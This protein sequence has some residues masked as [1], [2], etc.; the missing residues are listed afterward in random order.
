[1]AKSKK[2]LNPDEAVLE[3]TTSDPQDVAHR[4]LAIEIP[5]QTIGRIGNLEREFGQIR[6]D[7]DK[8]ENHRRRE[9]D[10]QF[11]DLQR[12]LAE[13][14]KNQQ[15][16]MDEVC[17]MFRVL[18]SNQQQ[19]VERATQGSNTRQDKGKGLLVAP[20]YQ[21]DT[22]VDPNNI[23]HIGTSTEVGRRNT[24]A[25]PQDR[26]QQDAYGERT[27]CAPRFAHCNQNRAE[28]TSEGEQD[29]SPARQRRGSRFHTR[30][31]ERRTPSVRYEFPKFNREHLREWL[32]MA[33]RYFLCHHVPEEE[34]I[35]IATANMTG[36]ATTHF[37]WFN[38]NTDNQTW[39]KYKAS[40][41][42]QFGDST[43]IDYDEDLKNI[44]QTTTVPA[45]KRQ[46]ERL[47]SMVR[48]PEK[49]LIGALKGALRNDIKREMKI[50]R[51][52]KLEECIAM[53][54]LYEERIEER[55]AEKKAHKFDKQRKKNSYPSGSRNNRR[56]LVPYKKE[57]DPRPY[58][59]SYQGQGKKPPLR[60][61]TPQQ[62][63]EYRR[64]GLCYRCE[65]KWD[66]YHKCPAYFWVQVI[67]DVDTSSCTDSDSSSSASYESSSSSSEEEV[68][69]TRRHRHTEKKKEVT[70]E[71]A[72]TKEE[73]PTEAESL[74]SMQNPNK[75][76]SFRV[77]GRINGKKILTLLDNGATRNFLTEEAARKC[78]VLLES[79]QPQTIVV[80]GGL[81]LKC[82][83]EGKNMEIVI[84]KKSFRIDFLVIPLDGVDLILGMP[85]FFTLGIISWD[86][87]NF[88]MTFTPDGE[89]ESMTLQ[90]ITSTTRPKAALRAIEAAQPACWV[91][92]L[93]T[94]VPAKEEQEEIVPERIQKVFDQ[95]GDI[96]E[97]PKGRPPPR[98]YDHK[99]IMTQG[100]EPVNV[101]PYRYGYNQKA[102]IER[103]VK[104]NLES[105]IVQP[106]SSPFSSPVLLVKKKDNTWRFCVDYHA[107]NEATVKDRHPI[108]VIDELLDE[109]A[110]ATI[111]SKI[112]LRVGY[113]QIRMDKDDVPKTAFRTH[114][115]HYEFLVMPFGLT[116]TPA[117]F[118]RCMNDIFRQYLRNFILVFFDDILIYS[119]SEELH[120]QHLNVALQVLRDNQLYA[121]RSKCSFGQPSIGYLGHIVCQQGVR[122]DPE[123]LDAMQRW[124]LPKDMKG[125]RGFLGLT[126]YYR[127]FIQ[128]Y[129]LIAQPLTQM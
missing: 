89:T 94:D 19:G 21:T 110:G 45:Y 103:L 53:A 117:T 4:V 33:E 16:E 102:E 125:L 9:M 113:H 121:K 112:D 88:S 37:L 23:S 62:I 54:R 43:F 2:N 106:S 128:G 129:G 1:M 114:D 38:H 87:R 15:K 77:F 42:L 105:G 73:K 64:K 92:A 7:M 14:R 107:L 49:A 72:P 25:P 82:L 91:M 40:L 123:K 84:K 109:L 57:N 28:F 35:E 59:N 50:H 101:R 29:E 108:P 66:K 122:A 80:G 55:R 39:E 97:E 56:E 98:S 58:H 61:L 22:E 8:A 79:S 90:G 30:Q 24:M 17:A 67:S 104:E 118:Q 99:I 95:Y 124:P 119:R 46:F 26:H 51:F 69:Q 75:P 68:I 44:V 115:G 126:G 127:R 31:E 111:F 74:H 36:E 5:E 86:V 60:Y 81:R 18:A 34:W 27:P 65:G 41:Q 63:E 100:A 3:E 11:G 96:F 116:N 52:E 48:W 120:E 78:N 12:D 83:S 13:M 20:N 93:A 71:E 70:K 85:W 32:F 47:A 6:R 10:R 76:N